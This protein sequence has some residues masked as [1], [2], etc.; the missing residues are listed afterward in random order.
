M[1]AQLWAGDRV[2]PQESEAHNRVAP[3]ESEAYNGAVISH[4]SAAALWKLDGVEPGMVELATTGQ[5]HDV[6]KG[7]EL[8]RTT[9]LA[10]SDFGYRGPFGVTG[11]VRTLIDL[12]AVVDD[13]A[14]V[15]AAMESA[16]RRGD[17]DLL[18]RLARRLESLG[19][20]GRRGAGVMREI[21]ALGDPN[22]R[23]T[24]SMFETLVEQM[25]RKAYIER[26]VRQHESAT[27]T[28]TSSP[29]STS[30][31]LAGGSTELAWAW[32]P[33]GSD[34]T[35][36]GP[37]SRRRWTGRTP[38]RSPESS[39]CGPPGRT[40]SCVP[41]RSS[42]SFARLA[43]EP[44][45]QHRHVLEF[46]GPGEGVIRDQGKFPSDPGPRNRLPREFL[47]HRAP[48][49]DHTR[50]EGLG[51]GDRHQLLGHVEHMRG[52]AVKAR[53]RGSQPRRTQPDG[54]RAE[55]ALGDRHAVKLL[56][57]HL[58]ERRH[59]SGRHMAE[60]PDLDHPLLG[61]GPPHTVDPG[62]LK[63]RKLVHNLGRWPGCQGESHGFAARLS[64]RPRKYVD[65]C[66]CRQTGL[67][68]TQSGRPREPEAELCSISRSWGGKLHT[69]ARSPGTGSSNSL[70]EGCW[71]PRPVRIALVGT[72]SGRM[73]G[74]AA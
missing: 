35:T 55:D 25:L 2:A 51:V 62:S 13:P 38:L 43:C 61:R 64:G 67:S 26:P 65:G 34:G 18:E 47:W 14:I 29:G 58:D 21:L 8:H 5:R 27:S 1:A 60:R 66:A 36:A 45:P 56:R 16:L 63:S 68:T 33:T 50:L 11:I 39:S 17:H 52:E 23:P 59:H 20:R 54:H 53:N 48:G 41:T 12:A 57:E 69:V 30:S 22:A 15:E 19:A 28:A 31:G 7:I 74:H 42:R 46:R 4:R 9:D 24:E 37:G 49:Q 32:T 71:H 72:G 70:S 6:P 73:V 44:Q 10:R 40:S 3:Q